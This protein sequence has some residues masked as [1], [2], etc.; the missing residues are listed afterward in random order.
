MT[1]ENHDVY[2]L[3]AASLPNTG[4]VKQVENGYKWTFTSPPIIPQPHEYVEYIRYSREPVE[5][6]Q[7]TLAGRDGVETME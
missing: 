3:L 2:E 1:D 4:S 7:H 6:P 5:K